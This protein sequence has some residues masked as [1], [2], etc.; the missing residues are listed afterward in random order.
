MAQDIPTFQYS[1]IDQNNLPVRMDRR[2]AAAVISRLY[3]PVKPRSLE[4][5]PIR[6]RLVNGKALAETEEILAFAAH[7]LATAPS[8]RGGAS[9]T[10]VIVLERAEG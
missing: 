8:I 9:A 5:W 4:K 3:F 10:S 6:W 7:K 1:Q 2:M